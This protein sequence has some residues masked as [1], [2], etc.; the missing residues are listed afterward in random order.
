MRPDGSRVQTYAIGFRNPYR[1][2]AFDLAGNMFHADNDNEDGSKFTGCRLM[3]I[4]EG[5]DFGWRLHQRRAAAYCRTPVQAARVLGELPGKM[6]PLCKTGRGSPAG[7]LI[8]ND[9]QF[10]ENYRGLLLY[11]D[12]FRRLIRAYKVEKVGASFAII[13]EFEFMKSDDPLF[14]PC[15]MV[16]G[17][18]GAIYVVDWRTDSGGAGRLSGDGVH[19]RIYRLSWSGTPDQPALPLRGMDSWAKVVKLDDAAIVK[20]LTGGSATDRYHAQQ[21]LRRRRGQESS[22]R[23]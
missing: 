11:P 2:V 6:P 10:P 1:D 9:G 3:H 19:G 22:G 14:R 15:H 12:V 20:A 21:E 17:P 16:A 23:C 18:D 5:N 7:L 4:A 13:E 8:Y